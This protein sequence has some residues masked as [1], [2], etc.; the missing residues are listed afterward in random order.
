MLDASGN[1]IEVSYRPEGSTTTKFYYYVQ[2]LQGD[3]IAL[4]DSANGNT[5]VTYTYDAWGNVL[6]TN[7][8]LAT[9]LGVLNPFRYRGYVYDTETRLYYLQSRYYDPNLGRFINA[10]ALASTGQGLIG[11]NM[12]AYCNNNPVMGCDPCGTCFHRMDFWNDCEKCGG[13]TLIEK[14]RDFHVM[15]SDSNAQVREDQRKQT[16]L[17]LHLIS[18]TTKRVLEIQTHQINMHDKA[19]QNQASLA[20][21]I[22]TVVS[23]NPIIGVD[24][25]MFGGSTLGTVG[26]VYSL[27]G[28][29]SI[30]YAGQ[31]AL[32]AVGVVGWVWSAG[33]IIDAIWSGI[34]EMEDNL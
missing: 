7:G 4:V 20:N 18:S 17:Q 9:T 25:I 12:F 34:S 19:I 10:D 2:N 14:A 24:M 28:I 11:N 23:N 27:A 26:T 32:A 8:S 6:S 31:V 21:K 22:T 15:V 30:P 29:V 16:E 1:P 33:R 13:R 5:V 3:V